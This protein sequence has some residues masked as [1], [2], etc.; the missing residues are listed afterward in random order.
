[1]DGRRLPAQPLHEAAL[2]ELQGEFAMV[3]PTEAILQLL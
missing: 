1:M 2:A 3:L